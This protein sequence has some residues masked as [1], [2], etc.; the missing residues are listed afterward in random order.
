MQ[1]KIFTLL[2]ICCINILFIK[3]Q[4]KF[5]LSGTISEAISNE[6]LIG[7]NILVPELQTGTTT[8]E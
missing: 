1:K 6:T 5:T 7:V 4:E 2:L 3:A 8:N